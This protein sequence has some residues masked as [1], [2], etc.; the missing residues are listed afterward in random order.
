MQMHPL[1]CS[2]PSSFTLYPVFIYFLFTACPLYRSASLLSSHSLS[3]LSLSLFIFT[4]R[5]TCRH[6]HLPWTIPFS[7][8]QNKLIRSEVRAY[9][10]GISI[11]IAVLSGH[12]QQEAKQ[13]PGAAEW[14]D[15]RRGDK[16]E[17]ECVRH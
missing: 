16:K 10:Q 8:R 14:E 13:E 9:Q 12:K 1:I 17:G 2:A 3:S 11:Q 4:H 5:H 7:Q 6:T 15:E